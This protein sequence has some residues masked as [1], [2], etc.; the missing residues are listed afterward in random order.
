ME[1]YNLLKLL[2]LVASTS[3]QILAR[4]LF[5]R[6]LEMSLR[7]G[8]LGLGIVVWVGVWWA[9]LLSF[10]RGVKWRQMSL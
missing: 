10:G 5:R 4:G 3:D 9:V 6:E 2:N 1:L 8:V 7:V